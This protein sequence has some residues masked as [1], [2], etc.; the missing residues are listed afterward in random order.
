[1]SQREKL[2]YLI[3]SYLKGDYDTKNFSSLFCSTFYLEKDNSILREEYAFFEELANVAD[4]F[5]PYEEDLKIPNVYFN[6]DQVK[7]KTKEVFENLVS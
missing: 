3:N 7:A 1:M 4:R 2:F 5:T 6:E